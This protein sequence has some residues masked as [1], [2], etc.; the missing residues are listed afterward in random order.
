MLDNLKPCLLLPQLAGYGYQ[1]VSNVLESEAGLGMPRLRKIAATDRVVVPVT[2]RIKSAA[3]DYFCSF[4]RD[5]EVS[6]FQMR[7]KIDSDVLAWHEVQ[8]RAGTKQTSALG[9]GYYDVSFELN[10]RAQRSDPV[11]DAEFISLYNA[12]G[13]NPYLFA[14]LLDKLVNVDLPEALG[15][16]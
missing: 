2:F 13:R 15:D 8:F 11:T 16:V 12:T 10:A 4:W 3:Y 14:D 5:Q 1:T 7:L 6:R 9:G